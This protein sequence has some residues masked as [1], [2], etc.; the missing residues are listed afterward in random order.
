MGWN[1]PLRWSSLL[2]LKHVFFVLVEKIV[3]LMVKPAWP[4]HRSKA[5]WNTLEGGRKFPCPKH[6]GAPLQ[7]SVNDEGLIGHQVC[8]MGKGL[9][10]MKYV[11]SQLSTL[12]VQLY[13]AWFLTWFL[14]IWFVSAVWVEIETCCSKNSNDTN[15]GIIRPIVTIDIVIVTVVTMA[16]N[17]DS[18]PNTES[19]RDYYHH[20][21]S[22]NPSI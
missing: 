2:T 17:D 20:L 5:Y 12:Y 16:T 8:G 9:V 7:V 22:P 19:D 18:D 11:T 4:F 10:M 3:R 14:V 15:R 6:S 21:S 1:M 13:P